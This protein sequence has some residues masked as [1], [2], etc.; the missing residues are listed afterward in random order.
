[1][2]QLTWLHSAEFLFTQPGHCFLLGAL[3]DF[4]VNSDSPLPRTAYRVGQ[5]LGTPP[6]VWFLIYIG[7]RLGPGSGYYKPLVTSDKITNTVVKQ[8]SFS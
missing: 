8:V 6:R 2:L 4:T 5:A 3:L 7:Y 1:M